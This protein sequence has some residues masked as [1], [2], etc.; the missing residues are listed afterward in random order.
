MIIFCPKCDEW[1]QPDLWDELQPGDEKFTCPECGAK[2]IVR[3]EFID[4]ES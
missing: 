3:I 4:D 2:W 1:I